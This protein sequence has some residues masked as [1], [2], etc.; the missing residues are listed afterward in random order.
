VD[1]IFT[2]QLR[3]SMVYAAERRK[4]FGALAEVI[5]R[6]LDDLAAVATLHE[7][8]PLPGRLEP[9]AR[10]RRGQ[11]SLRLTGNWRLILEPADD[12]PAV[13]PDG[14]VDPA[15]VEAVRILEV[16]DYH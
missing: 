8:F 13:K 15:A 11:F 9:L 7:A 3:K 10:D 16:V 14:S 1:I 5:G 4:R 12:P 6:R 2:K